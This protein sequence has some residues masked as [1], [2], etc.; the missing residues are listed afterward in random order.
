MEVVCPG[1]RDCIHYGIGMQSVTRRNAAGLNGE[2]LQGIGKWEWQIYI[3][4]GVV[5]ICS[6]EQV[7]VAILLA[8]RNRH[9]YR[10]GI[11]VGG[12]EAACRALRHAGASREQNQIRGLPSI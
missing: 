2:L 1:L 12:D 11:V 10:A 4:M 8:A 6:V 3:R 9:G 7:I 5:V